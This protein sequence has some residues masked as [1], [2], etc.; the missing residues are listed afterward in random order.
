MPIWGQKHY[1]RI[2]AALS[3]VSLGSLF[4][5]IWDISAQHGNF[6]VLLQMSLGFSLDLIHSSLNSEKVFPLIS[7]DF[8]TDLNII[9]RK[10][11]L[12]RV[13]LVS[14]MEGTSS[15]WCSAGSEG[16][17]NNLLGTVGMVKYREVSHGKNIALVRKML[18]MKWSS[19]TFSVWNET[20][21][22]CSVPQ[23]S[24]CNSRY[25]FFINFCF[26]AFVPLSLRRF[27]LA[28]DALPTTTARV[29]SACISLF[30]SRSSFSLFNLN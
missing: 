15:A 5:A 7:V 17:E 21:V 10:V 24:S 9:F 20:K 3:L 13:V 22:K 4:G 14:A 29:S 6:L 18:S 11:S 25:S 28:Q 2:R 16:D 12:S 26:A 23:M 19:G 27:T 30:S 8:G 1:S